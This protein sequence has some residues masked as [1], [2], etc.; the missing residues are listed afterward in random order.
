[1]KRT[2]E[3]LKSIGGMVSN[4]VLIRNRRDFAPFKKDNWPAVTETQKDA[5]FYPC[6]AFTWTND[7]ECDEAEYLSL[8]DARR[9]LQTWGLIVATMEQAAKEPT[10]AN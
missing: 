7:N 4:P 5:P 9:E 8:E 6:L 1:M 3:K 10:H 2:F